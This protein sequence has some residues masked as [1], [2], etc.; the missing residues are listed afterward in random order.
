MTTL[1]GTNNIILNNAANSIL[2]YWNSLP[3]INIKHIRPETSVYKNSI[4]MIICLMSGEF[5]RNYRIDDEFLD[6]DQIFD[7]ELSKAWTEEELK[8]AIKRHDFKCIS[9]DRNIFPKNFPDFVYNPRTRY[10]F[11]YSVIGERKV[12]GMPEDPDDMEIVEFYS[13]NLEVEAND[14]LISAVNIIIRQYNSFYDKIGK[15]YHSV[16]IDK[17]TFYSLHIRF[18]WE[19]LRNKDYFKPRWIGSTWSKYLDWMKKEEKSYFQYFFDI[20]P[21]RIE[22]RRIEF[23]EESERI[24][25]SSEKEAERTSQ[26]ALY[27]KNRG[28]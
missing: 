1:S 28:L 9:A 24:R 14:E 26:R 27:L 12:Q 2:E 15:Y 25:L 21:S 4:K 22:I 23:R 5:G 16:E 20:Q 7:E 6:K 3:N 19:N 17:K 11:L 8:L 10:S 18:C 13:K